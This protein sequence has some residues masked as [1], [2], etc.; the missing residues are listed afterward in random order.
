[1]RLDQFGNIRLR[2]TI[3]YNLNPGGLVVVAN[4]PSNL[5]PQRQQNFNGI[6]STSLDGIST[7]SGTIRIGAG[8]NISL[9]RSSTS[10]MFYSFDGLSIMN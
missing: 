4:L 6:G 8:G 1:M 2:G 5:T 9:I 3:R 7:E 10:N